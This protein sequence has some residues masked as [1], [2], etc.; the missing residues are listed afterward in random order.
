MTQKLSGGCACGQ[1]R[2]DGESDPPAMFNCHCRDCQQASGS[3]FAAIV[4][5]PKGAIR[6][7]AE[8]RYHRLTARSGMGVERGFCP[9]QFDHSRAVCNPRIAHRRR[10]TPACA[11]LL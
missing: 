11:H 6:I 3:A 2:Y 7:N 5:V 4:A 1:V 9:A 8:L 10:G